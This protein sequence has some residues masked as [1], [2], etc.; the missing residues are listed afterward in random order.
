MR[1]AIALCMTLAL[2][3]CAVSYGERAT[4]FLNPQLAD[5]YIPLEGVSLLV[6]QF[7]LL[8]S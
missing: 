6:L 7:A 1:T 5:A 4:G 8:T 3:G 2:S